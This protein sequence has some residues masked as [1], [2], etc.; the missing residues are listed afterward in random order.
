MLQRLFD[1]TISDKPIF[2][3]LSCNNVVTSVDI[4]PFSACTDIGRQILT[5][6]DVRIV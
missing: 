1:V 4:N 5:S 6:I 2:N 3:A